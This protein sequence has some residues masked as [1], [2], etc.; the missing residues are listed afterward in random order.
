MRR[1]RLNSIAGARSRQSAAIHHCGLE[2][3]TDRIDAERALRESEQ[4]LTLAQKA[5][6]LGVCEWDLSNV[7]I[8]FSEEY[9]PVRRPGVG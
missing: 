6:H 5:A 3:I 1:G 7:F 2:D 8:A 4:R 9:A